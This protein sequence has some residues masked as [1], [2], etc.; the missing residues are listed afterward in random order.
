[1]AGIEASSFGKVCA[2]LKPNQQSNAPQA[3]AVMTGIFQPAGAVRG[4]RGGR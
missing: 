2:L 3:F 1:M 4:G